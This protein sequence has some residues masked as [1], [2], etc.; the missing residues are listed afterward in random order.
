M[1]RNFTNVDFD[2]NWSIAWERFVADESWCLAQC[3]YC[4]ECG[5]VGYPDA[6]CSYFLDRE[7]SR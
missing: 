1:G 4:E 2:D 3:C 6:K 7:N 5:V